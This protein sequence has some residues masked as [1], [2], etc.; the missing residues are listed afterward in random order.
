LNNELDDY[1]LYDKNTDEV[2]YVEA[3]TIQKFIENKQFSKHWNNFEY[4]IKDYLNYN[5]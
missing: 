4:F 1:I 3:P 2:F 5:A